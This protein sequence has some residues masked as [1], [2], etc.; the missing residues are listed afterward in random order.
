ML[1]WRKQGLVS[2]AAMVDLF[3]QVERLKVGLEGACVSQLVC[4]EQ[5]PLF[6][7]ESSMGQFVQGSRL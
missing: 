7:L 5:F 4:E 6:S 3:I 1:S 2:A